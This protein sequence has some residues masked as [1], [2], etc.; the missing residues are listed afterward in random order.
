MQ[1]MMTLDHLTLSVNASFLID[2]L[3]LSTKIIKSI[4][5]IRYI[6]GISAPINNSYSYF[7]FGSTILFNR[8]Q[9]NPE[10]K[11]VG[12]IDIKVVN[13]LNVGNTL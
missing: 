2:F 13:M 12:N 6:H 7:S 9:E 4:I 1:T 5:K 3:I 8:I 11:S 10:L